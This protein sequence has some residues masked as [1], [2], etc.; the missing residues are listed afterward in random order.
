MDMF[1]SI[2]KDNISPS[3]SHKKPKTLLKEKQKKVLV[4]K[5]E[6]NSRIVI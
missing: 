5:D 6:I 2:C 1:Y 3:V 4:E